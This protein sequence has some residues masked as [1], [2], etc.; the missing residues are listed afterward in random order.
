MSTKKGD[1]AVGRILDTALDLLRREGVTALTQPRIAKA[2]GLRQ[3][4]ITYYFPKRS[5]LV[6]AVAAS[7]AERLKNGFANAVAVEG[8]GD[9]ADCFARIAT[10]EQTRLLLALVLAADQEK[11]IRALFRRLTQDIRDEIA[12]GLARQ[13]IEA[14]ADAV[15][16]FHA[17][18]VGLAVL[19]LA[20]SEPA[21]RRETKTTTK[22]ALSL[23]AEQKRRKA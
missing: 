4:H 13:G 5:D 21:A 18:G 22:R 23:M 2:S 8:T 20:R 11:S 1:I 3:S 14:D 9:I 16:L 17:L 10:P 15:A 19:D 7:V 12:I 6:A